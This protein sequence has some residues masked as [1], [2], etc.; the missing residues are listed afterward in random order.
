LSE[1]FSTRE[2]SP[3]PSKNRQKKNDIDALFPLL[4]QNRFTLRK[5]D[6][7]Q[8]PNTGGST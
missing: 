7:Y 4:G 1:R 8:N 5:F 6:L 2:R 3:S